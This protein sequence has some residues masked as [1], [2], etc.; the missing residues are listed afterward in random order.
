MY[1]IDLSTL[2]LIGIDDES[3]NVITTEGNFIIKESCR[4]IM[5]D[6]CKFFG[7]SLNERIKSTNRFVN[8]ASKT[9]I[10]IEDTRNIIFFPLKS[11]RLK[12][13]VWISFNNLDKYIK[14]NN[15]TNL[16]FKCGKQVTINYSY[17]IVDNQVTRCILLDYE[18]I[19]RRK[20]LK[21]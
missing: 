19:N 12:N 10:I 15:K 1:E 3:T 14:N 2:I 8:M 11:T 4:K 5:D 18:I 21:N 20:S 6:S 7:S 17:Y 9:P 13:N 16:K